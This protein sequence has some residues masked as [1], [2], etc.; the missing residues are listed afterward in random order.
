MRRAVQKLIAASGV[1]SFVALCGRKALRRQP[2]ARGRASANLDCA[3]PKLRFKEAYTSVSA[4]RAYLTQ[5]QVRPLREQSL[6]GDGSRREPIA[7]SIEKV[8]GEP[9]IDREVMTQSSSFENVG[10]RDIG[11]KGVSWQRVPP[12]FHP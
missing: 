11:E 6:T 8:P 9:Q 1:S 12:G 3:R 5:H 10:E 7:K 2:A 4:H